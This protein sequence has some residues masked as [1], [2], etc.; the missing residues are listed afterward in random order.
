M[1]N[2]ILFL[3]DE[4][5]DDII[6]DGFFISGYLRKQI[7]DIYLNVEGLVYYTA[8]QPKIEAIKALRKSTYS[9]S[10]IKGVMGLA[11]A[12]SAVENPKY[13]RQP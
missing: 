1:K 13:F 3:I 2:Y 12:K 4:E 10:S 11:M 5:Y 9:S 8:V 7:E 6:I